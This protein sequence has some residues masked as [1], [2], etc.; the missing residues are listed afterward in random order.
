MKAKKIITTVV[1][2]ALAVTSL[3]SF[4]IS[5]ETTPNPVISRNCPAYSESS[6]STAASANDAFYYSMWSGSAPDYLAYDLSGVPAEQREK[7]IAVWYNATGHYDYPV[8]SSNSNGMP[9]DYTIEVNKAAGGTCPESGW[10]VVEKVSGNTLHSRQHVVD[11]KG[12]NWIRL[13]VTGVD[14][15]ASGTAS[16]N[17]DIHNVSDGITDSWIFLGDS[18]TAGGMMNCYGTG[19]AEYVNQIDSRYYPVQEN[20]GIGGIMSS[21]GKENIDR[22]LETFPGNYV[23]IAYGTNDSWGNQ[24]GAQKYYD[25]TAY[26]VEKVIEAGKTPII[27]TIP[28]ATETGISAYIDDYNAMI[29]KIYTEYPEVVEG[30]DFY[31]LLQKNPEYLSSD[32]VHPNSEGYDAMRQEWASVMYE[33]VYKSESSQD[34]M[35]VTRGDINVDQKINVADYTLLSEFLI[36][37]ADISF[38][39]ADVTAD[40]NEDNKINAFD[41]VALRRLIAPEQSGEVTQSSWEISADTAKLQ[42]RTVEDDGATWLLQ[43]GS[44]AEFRVYAES[45][46]VVLKGN[47]GIDADADYRPRYAV[48]VDDELVIDTTLD[49]KEK[50]ITLFENGSGTKTVK[51]IMLSEA[52]YGAIGV[53]CVNVTSAKA[54]PVWPVSKNDISIEFIGDSI[55]C[56]YGVEGASQYEGFKTTTENFTKS[57][58]YLTAQKLGADYSALCYSGHGIVSGYTSDGTKNSE[59]LI[60]DYY[61]LN[62]KQAPYSAN[63]DFESHEN[64]AVVINL[65]TNDINYVAAETETRSAEFIDGYVDFLKTVRE[66]NKYAYII[67]TMGTMGGEEIYDLV[68]QAVDAYKTETGDEKIMSYKSVTHTQADGMGSDWH[69]SATTQQNSAYVLADKICQVLGMESD[70]VGLDVAADA[71]YDVVKNTADGAN[72]AHYVGYDKSFWINMVSG[73]NSADD[74]IATLSGIGLK[75]GGEYRLEFDCTSGRTFDMEFAVEGASK[76]FSDTVSMTSETQH[77]SQTFTVKAND[78]NASIN[79]YIGGGDSYNVTLSNIKLVKIK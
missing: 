68:A 54:E 38:N 11:M 40:V 15:K 69:P 31:T 3:G 79:F 42:G 44:A 36:G 48:Y 7:I 56:A 16:I 30:P 35:A 76:H 14:G 49:S 45:A 22:W 32:G 72:A 50:K 41:A 51:I 64:D 20:G 73:G 12:Y 17:F 60:P 57:Y 18:I 2:A 62:T 67:C 71:V 37:K 4:S 46:E 39:T 61:K 77:Y 25:N 1:S 27:P 21:H 26:M 70:Q 13:N 65:G 52:M 74:I 34:G 9:T 53:D 5:A 66:C 29:E 8:V 43:S 47:L 58:A 55:T 59:S 28:Y 78:A 75:N 23:S 24:T 10:E 33:N 63:W 6:P 19:F